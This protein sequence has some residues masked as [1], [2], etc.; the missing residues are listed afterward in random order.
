MAAPMLR[1]LAFLAFFVSLASAAPALT[2]SVAP[3][4]GSAFAPPPEGSGSPIG[5]LVSGCMNLLFDSGWVVTDAE[6]FRGPRS[7][8]GDSGGTLAGA[9]KGAKEGLVDYL[10]ALYVDWTPSS[11]NKDALLPALVSYSLVRVGDGKVILEGDVGGSPDSEEAAAHFTQ[12]A[13]QAGA[14]AALP[15]VKLLR[16]LA[17]G[18]EK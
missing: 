10:I 16:T 15:C 1:K 13:S 3:A 7:A 17:M 8:W 9:L 4:E 2:V 6:A 14:Q 11:F 5:Y 18:G 12:A